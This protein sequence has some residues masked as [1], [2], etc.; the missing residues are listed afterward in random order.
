LLLYGWAALLGLGDVRRQ[1]AAHHSASGL[2]SL[3][4]RSRRS[5]THKHWMTQDS[6]SIKWN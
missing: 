2:R 5:K 3:A 6:P 1:L 4:R